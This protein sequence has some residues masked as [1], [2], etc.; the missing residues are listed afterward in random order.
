MT[1]IEGSRSDSGCRSRDTDVR[2]LGIQAVK[3]GSWSNEVDIAFPIEASWY[4][5]A[6][7][8]TSDFPQNW[9]PS[10]ESSIL[11]AAIERGN[12]HSEPNL[13]PPKSHGPYIL[14]G[15]EVHIIE[16]QPNFNPQTHVLP[17]S[18]VWIRFY[19][20]PLDYWHINVIKDICK[21]LGTFV[22]VDDILEDKIWGS[23]LRICIS[24]YQITKISDEVKIIGAGKFWIQKIDRKDQL[25][26][27]PKCFSLDHTG[28]GCDVLAT[29]QRSYSCIQFPIEENRQPEPPISTDI[30][31]DFCNEI[32]DNEN[33]PLTEATPLNIAPPSS[34][35][36]ESQ[37]DL[38]M[39]LEKTKTLQADIES[40]LVDSLPPSALKTGSQL[41]V[42]DCKIHTQGKEARNLGEMGDKIFSSMGIELEDGEIE[43]SSS[44]WEEDFELDSDLILEDSTKGFGKSDSTIDKPNF[45]QKGVQSDGASSGL[46]IIWNPLNVQI[47]L[48]GEDKYW[49]HCLVTILGWNENFN[50][51]NVYGPSSAGD[52]RALWDHL[53]IRLCSITEGSCVV[54][55]DFNV[56]LSSNKKS[57]GI[58]RTSTTHKDFLEFVEKNHLIDIVP[59]NGVFTW[60]NRRS[61]FTNIVEW[62]DRFLV[63]G[64][65]LG[66][67]LVLESSI[68]P[69]I[70]SDHYS[71]YL[72]VAKGQAEGG[73]PFRF[74]KIWFRVPELYDLI[75]VWWNEPVL[76]NNSRLF[77]LNKKLK[78]IK[79]VIKEWNR[80]HFK[81]I[82]MEK[83]RI[84][85]EL[86]E[87]TNYVITLGMNEDLFNKENTLKYDLN[88]ILQCEEIHWR[89]KS[90]ELWLKEGDRNTKFFHRSAIAIC[91]RNKISEIKRLDGFI[92]R[93]YE[94][95][96]QEATRFFEY[97]MNGGH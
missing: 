43:S 83:L 52:K 32:H 77:I 75:S 11:G 14:D 92:V 74:E 57:G 1:A 66:Q 87:I 31:E 19:N 96:A 58:Q 64:D 95:I 39:L 63:T 18:K 20:C 21:D 80:G 79:V 50:L 27:F 8:P 94:D 71:I 34:D 41:V 54:F 10:P 73:T 65:W 33:I 6:K 40:K 70:G 42:E 13:V 49:Q 35:Q 45:K 89:Q 69:L 48:V 9:Q 53:T 5:K 4:H 86:E 72:E 91:N 17:D 36:S 7:Y 2:S 59:K 97:L 56:I 23:F 81:N 84:K 67:N 60:M 16:W 62:L 24:T 68:L 12:P 28:L 47:S 46:G 78:Y 15:I 37:Q 30:R 22:S 76:G 90:R 38:L 26:I 61:G 55:G 3:I 25:H 93:N 29:I 88:E 51:F 85:A 44:E 82:H